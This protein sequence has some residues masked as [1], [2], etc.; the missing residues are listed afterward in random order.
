MNGCWRMT[1]SYYKYKLALMVAPMP[2]VVFSV[3][4]IN[5]ASGKWYAIIN[6]VEMLFSI[7]I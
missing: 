4:Q 3:E 6:L 1:A 7:P 2:D 5:V